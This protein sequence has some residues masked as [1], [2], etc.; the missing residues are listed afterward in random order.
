MDKK[1]KAAKRLAGLVVYNTKK[2]AYIHYEAN[3][4][5]FIVDVRENPP[6]HPHYMLIEKITEE[7]IPCVT[8][9]VTEVPPV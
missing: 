9:T 5:R 2:P 8:T 3:K 1:F 7:I 6:E 4:S